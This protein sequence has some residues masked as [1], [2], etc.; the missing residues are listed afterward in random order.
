MSKFFVFRVLGNLEL[1]FI[2][3][4]VLG[5]WDFVADRESAIVCHNRVS[6]RLC[7]VRRKSH[8]ES[9]GCNGLAGRLRGV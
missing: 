5:I 6:L 9:E 8:G 3:K 4:R 7:R 1:E 2:C